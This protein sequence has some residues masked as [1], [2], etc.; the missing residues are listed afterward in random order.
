MY[1]AAEPVPEDEVGTYHGDIRHYSK[2][3]DAPFCS[4][5]LDGRCVMQHVDVKLTRYKMMMIRGQDRS[6]H[7]GSAIGEIKHMLGIY[8]RSAVKSHLN[9]PAKAEFKGPGCVAA[10]VRRAARYVHAQLAKAV[11]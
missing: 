8:A 6:I 10:Y 11:S 9:V 7:A 2:G 5:D 1:R 4:L 3:K